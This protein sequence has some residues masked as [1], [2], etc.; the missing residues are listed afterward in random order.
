MRLLYQLSHMKDRLLMLVVFLVFSA[1][2]ALIGWAL[3]TFDDTLDSEGWIELI[4]HSPS[5]RRPY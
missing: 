3:G 4:Y 5:E 1:V 2:M